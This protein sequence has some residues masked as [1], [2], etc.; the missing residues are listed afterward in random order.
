MKDE[1]QELAIALG[2]AQEAQIKAE[3][4]LVN[5]NIKI[6]KLEKEAAQK[7]ERIAQLEIANVNMDTLLQ[8]YRV[9]YKPSP[10]AIDRG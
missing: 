4:A 8:E 5:A 2:E 3:G 6:Q 7:D 1:A 10:A 9:E